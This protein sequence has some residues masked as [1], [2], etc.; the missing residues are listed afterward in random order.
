M[1][2][3]ITFIRPYHWNETMGSRSYRGWEEYRP[4]MDSIYFS[5]V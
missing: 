2:K 1:A 4:M 3:M 5:L